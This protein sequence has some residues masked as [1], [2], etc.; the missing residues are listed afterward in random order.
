MDGQNGVLGPNVPLAVELVQSR[1]L[2]PVPH[3][4]HQ[5]TGRHVQERNQ[6]ALP[7]KQ[8]HVK[9]RKIRFRYNYSIMQ[10]IRFHRLL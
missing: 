9:V 6:K 5:V 4:S 7:A 3:Q 10:K 2:E 8:Q 1:D